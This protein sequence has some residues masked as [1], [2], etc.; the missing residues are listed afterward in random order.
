MRFLL[1]WACVC[2]FASVCARMCDCSGLY[3]CTCP[4]GVHMSLR[5]CVSKRKQTRDRLVE[6]SWVIMTAAQ[7]VCLDLAPASSD[8]WS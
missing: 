4:F 5:T 1:V 3:M 8:Y 6:T 2:M 7:C